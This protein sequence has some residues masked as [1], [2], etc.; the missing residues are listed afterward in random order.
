[1]NGSDVGEAVQIAK[2]LEKSIRTRV[3]LDSQD[4]SAATYPAC[5]CKYILSMSSAHIDN[6]VT[7]I[8]LIVA[9]PIIFGISNITVNLVFPCENC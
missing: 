8:G 4:T 2:L 1:M 3:R 9:E 5:E 7:W 6:H